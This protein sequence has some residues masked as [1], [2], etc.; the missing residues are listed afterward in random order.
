MLL[1]AFAHTAPASGA[2][3]AGSLGI[4][5]R[6][7]PHELLL[8]EDRRTHALRSGDRHA[9][10][11]LVREHGG[12]MLALALRYVRDRAL[13]E[14]CVQEAFLQAFRSIRAFEGRSALKSWLF[15]IVVN[16]ALMKLRSRRARLELLLDDIGPPSAACARPEPQ[17][18]WAEVPTPEEHLT[19]KEV[20]ELVAA[21]LME[22][23]DCYR[24]VLLLRDIEGLSTEE[25]ARRLGMTQ[26]AVKVRLH[27]ARAALKVLVQPV[28]RLYV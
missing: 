24:I 7:V 1:E 17:P 21:K 14:D 5:E 23:P 4:E 11:R 10:E 2:P 27:R 28:L 12:W 20:C 22:L 6:A 19:R 13:A 9:G 26:G 3:I 15:R 25:T 18:A 16:T 8:A